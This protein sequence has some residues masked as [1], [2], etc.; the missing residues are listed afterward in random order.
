MPLKVVPLRWSVSLRQE[1]KLSTVESY[2]IN[3]PALSYKLNV[4]R[5]LTVLDRIIHI[6][7]KIYCEGENSEH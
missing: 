7:L 6:L 5:I 1:K 4:L 2:I 3:S